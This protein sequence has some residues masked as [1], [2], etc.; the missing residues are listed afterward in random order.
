MNDVV[1][2]KFK[3]PINLK[4]GNL[5]PGTENL[6]TEKTKINGKKK[7]LV[8]IV[9]ESGI[10]KTTS[11]IAFAQKQKKDGYPVIYAPLCK[12]KTFNFD[13]FLLDVF[14]TN[15]KNRI[16][17]V[18]EHEAVTSEKIPMLIIDNI[19]FALD[20]DKKIDLTLLSYLNGLHQLWGLSVIMISSLN[21]A[22]YEIEKC[23]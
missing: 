18:I 8:A 13:K 23:K 1:S 5:I 4:S 3:T 9:G 11:I 14:G 19:N 15:D 22:A 21:N 16:T 20:E 7:I 12:E 2:Q 6:F 10:G 17:Q